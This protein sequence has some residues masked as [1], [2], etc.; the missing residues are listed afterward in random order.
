MKDI[1]HEEN[2]YIVIIILA[3]YN[4]YLQYLQYVFSIPNAAKL[5][6]IFITNVVFMCSIS[7]FHAA[8]ELCSNSC[9]LKSLIT[10][11][12]G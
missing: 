5:F 8:C 3:E 2:I 12:L 9:V 1:S 10:Q 4:L 11:R 7:N 6:K